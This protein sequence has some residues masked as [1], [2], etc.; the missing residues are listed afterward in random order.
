MR[1]LLVQHNAAAK[2]AKSA[3]GRSTAGTAG[4]VQAAVRLSRPGRRT[5]KAFGAAAVPSLVIRKDCNGQ[6]QRCRTRQGRQD[7]QQRAGEKCRLAGSHQQRYN[8]AQLPC[9]AP[10]PRGASREANAKQRQS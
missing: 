7:Q 3:R 6:H 2:A 8:E 4:V 5:V 10:L 1:G 9:A